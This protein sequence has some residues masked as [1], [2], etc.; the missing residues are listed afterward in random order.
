MYRRCL[1]LLLVA[2]LLLIQGLLRHDHTW[3]GERHGHADGRSP[4]VHLDQLPF[5]P[6]AHRHDH[7]HGHHHH[8]G[9]HHHHHED[10]VPCDEGNQPGNDRDESCPVRDHDDDAI[11]IPDLAAGGCSENR[12]HAPGDFPAL[13]AVAALTPEVP[14]VPS[15]FRP[16]CLAP[17]FAGL[18]SCPVYLQTLALLI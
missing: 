8:H 12:P 11:D 15:E 18:F 7:E 17:P 13:T 9:G 16:H 10:D 14:F 1:C 2:Q 5:L 3:P 6:A 4:H